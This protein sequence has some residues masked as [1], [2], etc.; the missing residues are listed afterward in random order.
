MKDLFYDKKRLNQ[1]DFIISYDD[2]LSLID[3]EDDFI[4]W[5]EDF[6]FIKDIKKH[7]L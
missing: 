4:K 5:K 3:Q 6:I 7:L 2:M 1:R